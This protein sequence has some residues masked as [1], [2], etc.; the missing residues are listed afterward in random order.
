MTM[1]TTTD[2]KRLRECYA[3]V[4]SASLLLEFPGRSLESIQCCA[5]RLGVR[6]PK[7]DWRAIA[8]AHKPRI[9]LAQVVVREVV[10]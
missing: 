4:P 6:K 9:V 3:S 10:R 8:E 1:W 7:R 2:L 5:A